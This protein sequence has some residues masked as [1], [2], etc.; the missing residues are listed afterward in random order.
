MVRE[1]RCSVAAM[2]QVED[3]EEENVFH[4]GERIQLPPVFHARTLRQSRREETHCRYPHRR[5]C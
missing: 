4:G 3:R 5:N 2:R 1:K